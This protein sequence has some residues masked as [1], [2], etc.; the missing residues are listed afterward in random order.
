[1]TSDRDD[2]SAAQAAEAADESGEMEQRL[3]QLDEH[4]TDAAKKADAGR[5]RGEPP[6]GDPLDDVAGGGTDSTDEA[7]DPEGPIVGGS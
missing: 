5:P 4:I 3:E 1:M 6:A 2:R 7:D